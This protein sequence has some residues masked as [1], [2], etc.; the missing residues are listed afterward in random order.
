MMFPVLLLLCMAAQTVLSKDQLEQPS[1]YVLTLEDEICSTV[2]TGDRISSAS[3]CETAANILGF[4]W[5]HITRSRHNPA[6]CIAMCF[7]DH[8]SVYFNNNAD[9][10]VTS[11]I[12]SEICILSGISDPSGGSS[13]GSE[14]SIPQG[15]CGAPSKSPMSAGTTSYIVGGNEA[16]AHSLPWQISVQTPCGFHSCGATI[17]SANIVLTAAHCVNRGDNIYV[18]AGAHSLSRDGQKYKI[19]EIIP[20]S[21]YNIPKPFNNDIAILKIEGSGIRLGTNAMPACLPPSGHEWGLNTQFIVSGWGTLKPDGDSPDKLMQVTV[22]IADFNKCVRQYPYL[23]P[24][25]KKVLCAGL[26]QGGKDSCQGDS[27][28]P[29]VAKYNGKW[30]LAGVV[31]Y[32]KGCAMANYP[33]VY[34][35]VSHYIDWINQNS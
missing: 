34:T 7:S 24:S 17:I 15:T 3:E 30:T 35:H 31:S 18:K 1:E 25:W 27:G 11:S 4:T 16:E 26:D 19:Q 2:G 8:V 6:G 21:Q 9:A 29:L 22:P 28:G 13:G 32:G 23:T 5:T 10:N 14:D 12:H 20:H 33:G